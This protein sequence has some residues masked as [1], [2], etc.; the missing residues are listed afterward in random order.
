[1]DLRDEQKKILESNPKLNIGD[2]TTINM[3]QLFV[4]TYSFLTTR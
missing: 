4:S 3:T 1:M 2:V